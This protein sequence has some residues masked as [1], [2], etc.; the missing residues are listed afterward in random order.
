MVWLFVSL[1]P[2]WHVEHAAVG[3]SKMA[4]PREAAELSTQDGAGGAGMLCTQ[5]MSA[6][7]WSEVSIWPPMRPV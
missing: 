1:G 4:F 2:E 3:P 5:F 6:V 7:V